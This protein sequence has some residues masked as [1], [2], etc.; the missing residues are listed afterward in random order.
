MP[1]PFVAYEDSQ[2]FEL[3]HALQGEA[4]AKDEALYS[5]SPLFTFFSSSFFFFA[6]LFLRV[7]CDRLLEL[8]VVQFP[9]IRILERE[10]IHILRVRL[11]HQIHHLNHIASY[12]RVRMADDDE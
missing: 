10:R 1:W 3:I 12:T 8:C 11:I 9:P 4:K 2:K 6:Y 5:L 7:L